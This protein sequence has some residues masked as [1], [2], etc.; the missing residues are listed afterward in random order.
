MI[1]VINNI[2]EFFDSLADQLKISSNSG[3][4]LLIL[5]VALLLL[6]IFFIA[7]LVSSAKKRKYL[8]KSI[9]QEAVLSAMFEVSPD[10]I[11]CKDNADKFVKCNDI[12]A[13][14]AG[15]DESQLIGRS[16]SEMPDIGIRLHSEID[17]ADKKS[18]SESMKIKT[19]PLP[20]TFLDGNVRYFE[21]IRAPLLR[22]KG[23]STGIICI[24]RDLTEVSEANERTAHVADELE[25]VKTELLLSKTAAFCNNALK[26]IAAMGAALS[27]EDYALYAIL[28]AT[29][30]RSAVDIN[31]NGL[32]ARA[33]LLE[34][35][36]L[37][38]DTEFIKTHHPEFISA[39]SSLLAELDR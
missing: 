14:F 22:K 38:Q 2:I 8:R 6:I 19:P 15:A 4:F 5:A 1:N 36:V 33:E 18:I 25:V 17:A 31:V 37:R 27:E 9:E 28:V 16:L 39:L 11:V 21:S 35:A 7:N 23:N 34:D 24:F 10:M 32:T 13:R 30:R 20:L 29:I 12:F 3:L 26:H